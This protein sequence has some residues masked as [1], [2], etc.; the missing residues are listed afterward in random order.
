MELIQKVCKSCEGGTPPLKMAE[1]K[2]FMPQ[3]AGW[4]VVKGK[5]EK[6]FKFKDFVTAIKFINK[7]ALLAERE[8]HHPDF[9]LFS[10]NKIK[11][12]LYTHAINGLSENDFISAAKINALQRK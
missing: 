11:F 3:V 2:K 5:L 7:I 10:W 1:I 6:T 8:G 9:T 4:K 12:V